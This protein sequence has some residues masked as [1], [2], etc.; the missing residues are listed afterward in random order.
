MLEYIYNLYFGE[1]LWVGRME[2]VA[3]RYRFGWWRAGKGVDNTLV[4]L[5]EKDV[6]Q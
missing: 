2:L 3:I 6:F 5:V 4:S 1:L